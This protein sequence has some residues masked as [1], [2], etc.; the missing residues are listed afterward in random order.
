VPIDY[1]TIQEAIDA[2]AHGNEILVLPGRYIENINMKGKNIILRSTDPTSNSVI[3]LTIIDGNF[4]GTVVTFEGT[5]NES[6]VLKGFSIKRGRT[7]YGA[8]IRHQG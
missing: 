8:G 3:N 2:S 6:C 4:A 5:E 1:T 7:T